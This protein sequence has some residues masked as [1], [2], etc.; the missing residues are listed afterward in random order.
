MGMGGT[1]K[2]A[3]I[4]CRYLDRARFEVFAAGTVFSPEPISYY[5]AR[6]LAL[7]G[8][9][10]YRFRLVDWAFKNARLPAFRQVVGEN[11]LLVA[12]DWGGLK[13]KLLAVQP[14]ILHVHYSGAPEPPIS[15]EETMASIPA[16]VTTNQFATHDTSPAHRRVSRMLFV[17]H[18]LLQD[19]APWARNDP[20]ARVLYNPIEKPKSDQD[21]RGELNIPASAFVVG[22]IGRPS[23]SIYHPISLRAYREMETPDTF[24]VAL[25]PSLHMVQEARSLGLKRFIALPPNTDDVWLSKFCNTFDVLA[26]A[27]RDGETFGCN[28]AE[29]MMHGKPVVSHRAPLANAQEEIIGPTGFVTD[30]DDYLGYADHLRRLRD[31]VSLR[32]DLGQKA[33]Q[34]ALEFFEA[35]VVTRQLEGFYEE[36]LGRTD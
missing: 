22:R 6:F 31:D 24:F 23:S 17:S 19:K 28:I 35:S 9:S 4:F 16:T 8:V 15:D 27:R 21:L 13:P 18:H 30:Y 3:E 33:R 12:P 20:R 34:R 11:R 7:L 1:E 5:K 29:A 10:R 26:H 25:A 36:S 32:R 14:D 2:T